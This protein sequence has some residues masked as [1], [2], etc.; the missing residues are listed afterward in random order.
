MPSTLVIC[1]VAPSIGRTTAVQ[2]SQCRCAPFSKSIITSSPPNVAGTRLP[3]ATTLTPAETAKLD[4][5]ELIDGLIVTCDAADLM[6][7]LLLLHPLSQRPNSEAL[8]GPT[9]EDRAR[10]TADDG[11][12]EQGTAAVAFTQTKTAAGSGV[13]PKPEPNAW[14]HIKLVAAR[15]CASLDWA[16]SIQALPEYAVEHFDWLLM[17]LCELLELLLLGHLPDTD[18]DMHTVFK[19]ALKPVLEAVLAGRGEYTALAV[20]MLSRLGTDCR[21]IPQSMADAA[22]QIVWI[23]CELYKQYCAPPRHHAQEFNC[24]VG[25]GLPF[26]DGKPAT[27]AKLPQAV[28]G[29]VAVVFVTCTHR[30]AQHTIGNS[31]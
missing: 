19:A 29:S 27:S 28:S 3:S 7:R 4:L 16:L 31:W 24:I 25:K 14:R 5:H 15:A 17:R 9:A 21:L 6:V 20:E 23:F 26:A 1:Q 2:G 22:L 12:E 30:L 11:S 13:W 8:D 10:A 18:L